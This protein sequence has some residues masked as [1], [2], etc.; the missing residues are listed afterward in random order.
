LEARFV[1]GYDAVMEPADLTVRV[2]QEIRGEL[3]GL[4]DEQRDFREEQRQ[5]RE[6]SF[7]RFEAIE[8]TLRDLAEQ[9]IML[10]RALK[11]AVEA[12]DQNPQRFEAIEKRLDALEKR[13]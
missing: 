5:F 1:V 4:R 9:L 2:L 8:T 10:A 6:Q 7:A 13:A 12:R 11:V 3:R